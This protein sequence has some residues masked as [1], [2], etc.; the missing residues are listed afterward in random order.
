MVLVSL[1]FHSLT[2]TVDHEHLRLRLGISL[3]RFRFALTT[4]DTH[5]VGTDDP[6]G[7]LRALQVSIASRS[8]R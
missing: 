6:D 2:V 3:I 5:R 8:P 1:L 4:G 7:L